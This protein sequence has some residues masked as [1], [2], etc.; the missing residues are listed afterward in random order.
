MSKELHDM[1]DICIKEAGEEDLDILKEIL[2]GVR[3]KHAQGKG[4]GFMGALL[5]MERRR[6]NQSCEITIPINPIVQ[7]S[8]GIVHGGITATLIDSAMGSLANTLVPEGFAT[9]TTQLNIHYIAPGIGDHLRCEAHVEHKGSKT[10]VLSATVYR[11]DGKKV[12][13]SSGSFFII[14]KNAL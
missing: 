10:M 8:L 1:L 9:V 12:A 6:D 11:P 2:N 4:V 7:N 3:N 14:E 5:Q 13:T